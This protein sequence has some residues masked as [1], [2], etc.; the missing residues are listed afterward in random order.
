MSR[1]V[2]VIPQ[3]PDYPHSQAFDEIALTLVEGLNALGHDAIHGDRADV[4]DRR[5]IVLGPQLLPHWPHAVPEDAILYNLEQVDRSSRWMTPALLDRFRRHELWDYSERN[6]EALARDHGITHAK[7]LPVGY[8]P[9]LERIVDAP[10]HDIDVLFYG[11]LNDRRIAVLEGLARFGVKVHPLFGVYGA[12]RDAWIARSKIV[13][14]MH[15]YDA[16]VFEQVRV[17]YLLANA[18]FVVS[19][20]GDPDAEREWQDGLAFAPYTRLVDTCLGYL[21]RDRARD[22]IC[23]RG[24][25]LMRARPQSAYLSMVLGDRAQSLATHGYTPADTGILRRAP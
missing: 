25:E 21:E 14:N 23:L 17:S 8:S 18:C 9:G 20:S 5:A 19:E 7:L 10:R 1:Y 22:R 4:A 11:S 12:E 16:Q 24:R 2:V 3:L 15:Y 13:L 6:R